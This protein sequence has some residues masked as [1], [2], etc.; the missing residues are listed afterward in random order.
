MGYL[1]KNV[2]LVLLGLVVLLAVSFAALTTYYHTTYSEL[3]NEYLVK[4]RELEKITRDL[5]TSKSKLNETI[6][7][8]QL[9]DI[10]EKDLSE[11]YEYLR[12]QKESLSEMLNQTNASLTETR[13]VLREKEQKLEKALKDIEAKKLEII[14][15]E[16]SLKQSKDT[17]SRYDATARQLDIVVDYFDN[18]LQD[19][20]N[21]DAL[22]A[23][24]SELIDLQDKFIPIK[25][26]TNELIKIS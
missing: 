16:A 20:V 7:Q 3:S 8:F 15:L 5:E 9:K 6:T 12:E 21:D 24:S 11:K 10:R 4:L 14:N 23:C 25:S 13:R 19:Y 1:K 18:A 22:Q 17:V 26:R 2:N